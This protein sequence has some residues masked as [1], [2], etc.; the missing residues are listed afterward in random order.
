[1]L[2]CLNKV[3]IPELLNLMLM[4]FSHHNAINF[5]SKNPITIMVFLLHNA[6]RN[7]SNKQNYVI[8]HYN[9]SMI[10]MYQLSQKLTGFLVV[11]GVVQIKR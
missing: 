5:C 11:A 2:F 7:I 9:L 4:E 1:M 6:P 3:T 10:F 8:L